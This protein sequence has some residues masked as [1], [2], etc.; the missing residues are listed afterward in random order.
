MIFF[1][2]HMGTG[3]VVEAGLDGCSAT[4]AIAPKRRTLNIA[5]DRRALVLRAERRTLAIC[6]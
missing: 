4:M 6:K 5:P 3:V 1:L 2:L